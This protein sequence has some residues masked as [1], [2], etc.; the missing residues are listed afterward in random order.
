MTASPDRRPSEADVCVVGAGPAGAFVAYALSQKDH[1]IVVL[2]AGERLTPEDHRRRMEQWLRADFRREEFWHE[3]ERDDY[4]STGDIYA[5]L[6]KT[7]VKAVGG[8]SLH[9]GA[10][11]PRLHE[12]D[13]EMDTRYGLARDWPISYADLRPYY[14]RAEH[15]M[16]VA[17]SADNPFGPPR[18]ESFPLPAFPPSYS[19]S[20]FAEACEELGI[21]MHAQPKAINS[22][23]HDDRTEC[24]GYGVC[25]ACPSGAKYTADVHVRKAEAEGARI[26]DQAQV[27]SVEH[28][29][30]G[31]HVT[32]VVYATPDGSRYRQ[33]ADHIVLACGGIETPRLLLLSDSAEYPDGLANSSGAV[34]R[35]LM[36]HPNVQTVGQLDEP[37]RQNNI[38]WI[39]SRTDQFYDHE[40]ATPGSFFLTFQNDA[41]PITGGAHTKKPATSRLLETAGNASPTAFA[42]LLADPF[43]ETQLGD[44]LAAPT[45]AD[46]PDP[47]AVRGVAEMLPRPDNRVTLDRSK[48]DN[49]GRP[50]PSIELSDGDHARQTMDRC[51]E[52]QESIMNELGAESI[53]VS[54]LD[55]RPMSTHHMG[56]TRMGTDSAESVV[57]KKCRTH[58]LDN[59]WIASSSVFTTAGA[60]NPTLTIVALALKTA[61][62]IDALL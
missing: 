7:R 57:N 22:E 45:T 4:T 48:T 11:T 10:N 33:E 62:H 42:E 32:G 23:P 14:A 51:L 9:W 37:T 6:N 31:N 27:L 47:I 60:M 53:A 13:F 8:T 58:D 3:E 39:S 15:E 52:V 61:D 56:T 19:D 41:K 29:R 59:L 26:V 54:T 2:E 24:V 21:T 49:H 18:E 55:N 30:G 12:K 50:V 17:G 28:D 38:G 36:D 46:P 1:D 43:A 20:L 16:G 5:R 44:D 34:G 35:Y 25:N 40:E